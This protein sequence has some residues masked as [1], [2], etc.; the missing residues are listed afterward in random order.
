M[1]L[2]H[3]YASHNILAENRRK[4]YSL[5][6]TFSYWEHDTSLGFQEYN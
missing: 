3:L 2:L 5:V 6:F 4:E 1:Y